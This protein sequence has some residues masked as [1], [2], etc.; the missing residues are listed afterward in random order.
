MNAPHVGR[1]DR[2]RTCDPLAP[3]QM[4]YQTALHPDDV[5]VMRTTGETLVGVTGFEPATSASRTRRSTS[6]S[7][8]PKVNNCLC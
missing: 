5:D 2:I 4:R 8:T 3:S 1:D 6:L 7:Y